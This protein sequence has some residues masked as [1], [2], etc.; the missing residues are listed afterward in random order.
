MATN[1]Q[2]AKTRKD[3]PSAIVQ[4]EPKISAI[5]NAA[6]RIFGE[7]GYAGASMRVIA[8]EAGVAQALLH[9][10][11]G[12]KEN[13]YTAV[14]ERRSLAIN[15]YRSKLLDDLLQ[16]DTP[17]TVEDVL[18]I[19]FTPLTVIFEG[20][21]TENLPYY[22]QMVAAVS[23]GSDTRS[24]RIREQFYDPMA[25]RF[26]DALRK[27]L[28][29]ITH[30]NAVFAYLFS[31]GARQQAHA[32]NDRAKNLGASPRSAKSTSHYTQLVRFAAAGIRALLESQSQVMNDGAQSQS[33]TR[34]RNK[35]K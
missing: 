14:F 29:E 7:N 34:A 8:E 22:V 5:L 16:Q 15:N 13:L 25:A 33:H 27:V 23:L 10:H 17:P 20:Q 32:L 30:D 21:D 1:D 3:S 28:P 24:K 6:E 11:Y 2:R 18:T 35:L 4:Q 31:I 9:Y 26:I 12:T 19:A